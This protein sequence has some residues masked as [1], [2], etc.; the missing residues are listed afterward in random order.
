ME[1][2]TVADVNPADDRLDLWKN[3]NNPEPLPTVRRYKR[4]GGVCPV[5]GALESVDEAK[6]PAFDGIGRIP[7]GSVTT[8]I[9]RIAVAVESKF[10]G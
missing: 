5:G 8:A 2:T 6:R 4:D 3:R 10:A 1:H 9:E 7:L